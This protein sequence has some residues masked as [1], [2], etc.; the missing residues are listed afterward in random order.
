M[1]IID[2]RTCGS[3]EGSMLIR[4]PKE[5]LNLMNIPKSRWV[6][7]CSR[8]LSFFTCIP[9]TQLENGLIINF[10]SQPLPHFAFALMF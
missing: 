8:V 6:S 7:N 5:N 9:K 2:G 10:T 4:N 3:E 1:F